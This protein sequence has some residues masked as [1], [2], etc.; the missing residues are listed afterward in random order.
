MIWLLTAICATV[1]MYT[2]VVRW[3]KSWKVKADYIWMGKPILDL[4]DGHLYNILQAI[5]RGY[6]L[7]TNGSCLIFGDQ[8]ERFLDEYASRKFTE[9]SII[10]FEERNQKWRDENEGE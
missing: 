9:T 10:R 1:L 4:K 7:T 3:R 8:R 5:H 2:H 6:W